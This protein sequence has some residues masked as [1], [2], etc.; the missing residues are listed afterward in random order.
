MQKALQFFQALP[1][2]RIRTVEQ[3]R[4]SSARSRATTSNTM[5]DHLRLPAAWTYRCS[6]VSATGRGSNGAGAVS[7]SLS[8]NG[9]QEMS[10][11]ATEPRPASPRPASPRRKR[12]WPLKGAPWPTSA[13]S[14][15]RTSMYPSSVASVLPASPSSP[16]CSGEAV[17]GERGRALFVT[18]ASAAL[19]P[20]VA[21]GRGGASPSA[22]TGT[23]LVRPSPSCKGHHGRLV[24]KYS[25]SWGNRAATRLSSGF[26][27]RRNVKQP[28]CP[29]LRRGAPLLLRSRAYLG[30]R[31]CCGRFVVDIVGAANHFNFVRRCLA[32][33]DDTQ[34]QAFGGVAS[35]QVP[36][37]HCALREERLCEDKS[38]V[39]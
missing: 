27:P 1:A 36:A 17:A 33:E 39:S 21:V 6:L 11:V 31:C 18:V 25:A 4:R 5:A 16:C 32:A 12:S 20:W 26:A 3:P 37:I 2:N 7:A 14:S 15:S 29:V 22:E 10:R 13:S 8:V 30:Q 24:F 19:A 9:R 34:N 35:K 23:A 38:N 28:D